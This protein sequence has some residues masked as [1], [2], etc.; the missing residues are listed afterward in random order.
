M[1]TADHQ[2]DDMLLSWLEQEEYSL[3]QYHDSL[4]RKII[5]EVRVLQKDRIE[6]TFQDGEMVKALV[7]I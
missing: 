5:K 3:K 2:I 7:R 4:V 6:V 1:Q